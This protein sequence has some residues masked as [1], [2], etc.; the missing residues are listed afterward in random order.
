MQEEATNKTGWAG[1]GRTESSIISYPDLFTSYLGIK[2]KGNKVDLPAL[3]ILELNDEGQVIVS[4]GSSL[5]LNTAAHARCAPNSVARC[6]WMEW[7]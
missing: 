1:S 4:S 2:A 7:F 6:L 3:F 5:L